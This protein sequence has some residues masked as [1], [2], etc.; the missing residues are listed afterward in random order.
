M[1]IRFYC[2]FCD[3]LLGIS[4]RKVGAVVE[5]PSCHGQVGVPTEEAT[6]APPSTAPGLFVPVPVTLAANRFEIVLTRPQ[7]VAMLVA[8]GLMLCLSFA[9]GLLVGAFS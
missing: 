3:Q 9:A 6:A 5:C 4:R 1:P 7:I 8:L 2:P